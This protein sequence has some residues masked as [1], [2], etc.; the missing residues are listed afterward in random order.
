MKKKIGA[1]LCLILLL[2]TTAC[3]SGRSEIPTVHAEKDEY[4][5]GEEIVIRDDKSNEVLGRVTITEIKVLRNE[6]FT[7]QRYGFQEE[8]EAIVRLKYAESTLDSL[9]GIDESNFDIYD[10]GGNAAEMDLSGIYQTDSYDP[11]SIIFAV[12]EKGDHVKIDF[13]FHPDSSPITTI[14]ATYE[15]P[16]VLRDRAKGQYYRAKEQQKQLT[17]THAVLGGSAVV[18]LALIIVLGIKKKKAEYKLACPERFA[19]EE[20]KDE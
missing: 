19:P 3:D 14:T 8:Y 6:T 16:E 7:I 18:L 1:I 11:N 10:A 4:V 12:K 13:S 15:P 2:L 20:K 17:T 9:L 5:I